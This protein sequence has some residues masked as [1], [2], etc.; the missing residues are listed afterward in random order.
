[1]SIA[2]TPTL[3]ALDRWAE[4]LGI[5]PAH[6]NEGVGTNI[7]PQLGGGC[8][9]IYWQYPWQAGGRVSREEIAQAIARAEED[10][11]LYLGYWPAPKWTKNELVHMEH[12]Y[13]R[14]YFGT[15]LNI[16]G[17]HKAVRTKWGR[18]IAGGE[19]GVS[20][21][22]TGVAVVYSDDDGDG[23]DE[24]ATVS[25]ATTLTDACEI[26]VYFKGHSEQEWEIRPAR[27]KQIS[28]GTFT[29]TFWS[30]QLIDPKRWFELPTSRQAGA[31]D[32]EAAIYVSE[33]DVYREYNDYS[34]PGVVFYWEDRPG[35][36]GS[37][38][39]CEHEAQEG[40]LHVRDR[41]Q[42]IAV[43]MAASF[44]GTDWVEQ[45]L[46]VCR[47]PDI[48]RVSYYHGE[49]SDRYLQ[50]LDCDPLSDWWAET[51][52]WLA[53][54][55]LPRPLC[56]CN[57]VT[58]LARNL[59]QDLAQTEPDGPSY[60]LSEDVLENPF[61]SRRGEVIAWRRVSKLRGKRVR[62]AVI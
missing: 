44:D 56:S 36:C 51:I 43:P 10:I 35:G 49:V 14:E 20:A 25:C 18:F 5:N 52:A 57:N 62:T 33:V 32:L 38:P 54:A 8:Q 3:L 23:Y 42:G 47:D 46:Q 21:V 59:M 4:I 6:F 53:T 15:G 7:M 17:Q 9:D 55:R 39:A 31:E 1:M 50:G 13:R 60:T 26:K 22:D 45:T 30:W 61:G 41:D 2:K 12:P 24:T 48:L 16:K 27:T 11:A 40:C 28:G 58:L 29:A 37:C 19:R 34:K